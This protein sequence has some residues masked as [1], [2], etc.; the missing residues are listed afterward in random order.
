MVVKKVRLHSKMPTTS[1]YVEIALPITVIFLGLQYENVNQLTVFTAK[2]CSSCFAH[3]IT[4]KVI[5]KYVSADGMETQEVTIEG[6][7][8]ETV[9][10]EEGDT[11]S[12]VVKRTVLHSEGDQ[13]EVSVIYQVFSYCLIAAPHY[14]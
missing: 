5:R 14:S 13:K 10:I 4:R 12:R 11:V 7:H 8:Q 1:K 2:L 9:Q 3:Q 6:S